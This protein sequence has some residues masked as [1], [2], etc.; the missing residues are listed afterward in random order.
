VAGQAAG[1]VRGSGQMSA[2]R[3]GVQHFHGS[4]GAADDMR[5]EA[6]PHDLDLGKLRHLACRVGRL[7][8]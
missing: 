3:P 1:K 6:H 5:V 7:P 4:E 2:N 8:P